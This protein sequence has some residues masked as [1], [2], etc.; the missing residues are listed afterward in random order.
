MLLKKLIEILKTFDKAELKKFRRFISSDYFNTNESVS[1]LFKL[2][3]AFYPEFDVQDQK[4]SSEALFKKIY[5][6][7]KYDEKTY[8]YLLSSL[9][10]LLEKYLAISLFENTEVE[11]KKYVV[12]YLTERRLFSLAT[13][14]LIALESSLDKD[15]LIGGEYIYNKEDISYRIFRSLL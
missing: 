11:M 3:A 5:G 8:R 10:A 2:I 9:Y 4:L 15:K 1:R 6:T 13:K 7:R 14:N 12:D